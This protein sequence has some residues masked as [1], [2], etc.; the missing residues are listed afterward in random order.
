MCVCVC[1]YLYTSIS[2]YIYICVYIKPGQPSHTCSRTPPAARA[3]PR[4]SP[5]CRPCRPSRGGGACA[6][7]RASRRRAS[8]GSLR[9]EGGGGKRGVGRKREGDSARLW[10]REGGACRRPSEHSSPRRAD[11]PRR[12]SSRPRSEPRLKIVQ[13]RRVSCEAFQRWVAPHEPTRWRVSTPRARGTPVGIAVAAVVAPIAV[14]RPRAVAT[15]PT[16]A[17]LVAVAIRSRFV[18]SRFV[19]TRFVTSRFVGRG[20]AARGRRWGRAGRGRRWGRRRS[21]G[22]RV[23][24]SRGGRVRRSRGGRVGRGRGG[25]ARRGRSGRLLGRHTW[26]RLSLESRRARCAARRVV[27][28][29]EGSTARGKRG[30]G[31]VKGGNRLDWYCPLRVNPMHEAAR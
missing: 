9:G 5:G 1:V 6:R 15:R 18:A 30:G 22:G 2:V 20:Q 23:R 17:V 4:R 12:S 24:R 26:S 31:E 28:N 29:T 13:R 21:R 3:A 8:G 25:R 10:R 7:A 11:A 16:I 14:A 27:K 19:A